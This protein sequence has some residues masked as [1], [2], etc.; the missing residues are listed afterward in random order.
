MRRPFVKH[1]ARLVQVQAAGS[2]HRTWMVLADEHL[3]DLGPVQPDEGMKATW[4]ELIASGQGTQDE[5][6]YQLWAGVLLGFHRREMEDRLGI[7][8]VED[9]TEPPGEVAAQFRAWPPPPPEGVARLLDDPLFPEE[10]GAGGG[11][12]PPPR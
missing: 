3:Y 9:G 12:A 1:P 2:D 7:H 8:V 5:Y 4:R 11:E 10:Q 6:Q